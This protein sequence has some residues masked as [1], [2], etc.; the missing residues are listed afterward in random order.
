MVAVSLKS[1]LLLGRPRCVQ[2]EAL[3]PV[4]IG[5][6]VVAAILLVL[7]WVVWLANR[8]LVASGS[9]PEYIAF[10][11]S[12]PLADAWVALAVVVAAVTLWRRRPSA[13]IWLTA[14]GGAGAYLFAL[15]V[16]FDLQHGIYSKD[17]G[18]VIELMI[19]F[20]TVVSGVGVISF[21]WRFRDQV[22]NGFA[23]THQN[24]V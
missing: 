24:E 11:Q 13:L 15:D 12:F 22:S 6:L 3:R 2:F 19:N 1:R 4:V 10:E 8:S 23:G 17:G 21:A 16:L 18:G 9:T 20:M 7:Y 14:I 5:W